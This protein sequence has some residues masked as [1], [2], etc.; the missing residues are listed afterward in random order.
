MVVGVAV[1]ALAFAGCGSRREA[2]VAITISPA[3]ATAA[4]GFPNRTVQFAADGDF[5]TYGT[6]QDSTATA[7]CISKTADASHSLDQVTWATSDP[8]NTSIDAHGLA[9][10]LGMTAAPATISA[11]AM[12]I[13]GGVKGTAT[14]TCN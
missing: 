10:C 9:T 12:G 7:I 11:K 6:Y 3:S 13:C 1:T 14:L 4:H 2:L 5:G 8:T